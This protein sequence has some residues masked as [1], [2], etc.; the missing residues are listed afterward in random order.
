MHNIPVCLQ[1]IT[2]FDTI[3]KHKIIGFGDSTKY[4]S[5]FDSFSTKSIDFEVMYTKIQLA[6]TNFLVCLM[7]DAAVRLSKRTW[8]IVSGNS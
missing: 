7:Q 4:S 5:K 2:V 6:P 3:I 1:H 8:K